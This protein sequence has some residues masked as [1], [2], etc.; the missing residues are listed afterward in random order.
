ML[1]WE[2]ELL[3]RTSRQ[4]GGIIIRRGRH[5]FRTGWSRGVRTTVI[6]TKSRGK[7]NRGGRRRTPGRNLP[8]V[9]PVL[10]RDGQ[11]HR[12]TECFVCHHYGHF[13]NQCSNKQPKSI[14]LTI[15]GVMM[16][17]NGYVI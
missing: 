16:M 7:G 4:L 10:G 12:Y 5:S 14:N 8:K 1:N 2:Y 13:S 17:Q 6:F 3:V 15:I 11:L 9:D